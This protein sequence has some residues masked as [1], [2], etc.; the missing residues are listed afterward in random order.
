MASLEKN[1]CESRLTF[2]K[3]LHVPCTAHVLVLVV[4]GGLKELGNPSLTYYV[5]KIRVMKS[6]KKMKWKLPH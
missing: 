5:Q 6:V 1:L 4:Q 3:Q 2:T